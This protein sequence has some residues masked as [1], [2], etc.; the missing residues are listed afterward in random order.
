LTLPAWGWSQAY[1][2]K[3]QLA[4][5]AFPI[6]A[7]DTFKQ[8]DLPNGF[9]GNIVMSG[10]DPYLEL[11]PFYYRFTCYS[12]GTL[13]F[14]II[15]NLPEDNYDWILFDITGVLPSTIFIDPTPW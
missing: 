10:C 9:N 14:I 4:A 6:C 15:P 2:L 8:G 11:N 13:G 5:T 12:A 7:Q 3:G 1:P